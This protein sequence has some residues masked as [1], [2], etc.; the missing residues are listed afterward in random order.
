[1]IKNRK[2]RQPEAITK[3]MAL[4]SLHI[5]QISKSSN[6]GVVHSMTANHTLQKMQQV[7]K[8]RQIL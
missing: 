5:L 2:E 6:H 1:M 3:R 8:K 7:N 4:F